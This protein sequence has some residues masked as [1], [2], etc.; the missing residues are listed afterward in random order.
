MKAQRIFAKKRLYAGG[1]IEMVIWQ[2]PTATA[3]RSHGLK[4]RLVY[5]VSGK[6]VVGYDNERGKGDHEHLGATEEN[7]SFVSVEQLIADFLADVRR[8]K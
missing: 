3:E 5:I 2:L 1:V 7:Y 4:Y 6:R 8:V